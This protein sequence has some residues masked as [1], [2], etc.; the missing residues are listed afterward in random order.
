VDLQPQ[1]LHAH[2]HAKAWEKVEALNLDACLFC[3]ACTAVC[4]S[5]IPLNDEFRAGAAAVE[6][7]KQQREEAKVA[8][9]RFE[10]RERRLQR[11]QALQEAQREEKLKIQSM[12]AKQAAI[13]AALERAQRK[14]EHDTP[15]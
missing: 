7:Q 15:P 13:Q 8:Q 3:H 6:A 14:F 2:I 1:L 5:A 9:S 11:K 4:P 10:A 12:E